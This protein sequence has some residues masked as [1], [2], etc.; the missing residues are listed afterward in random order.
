MLFVGR[1]GRFSE[2]RA[3]ASH[4]LISPCEQPKCPS[5]KRA[6]PGVALL[7]ISTNCAISPPDKP[8]ISD[9]ASRSLVVETGLLLLRQITSRLPLVGLLR[10]APSNLTGSNPVGD[11]LW[12]GHKKTT[13]E[14]S[15]SKSGGRNR[16]RTCVGFPQQIYSLPSL[17]A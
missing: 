14:Q 8:R 1:T 7:P 13:S 5:E 2:Y 11:F 9:S 3:F 4:F 10:C 12:L 15:L 16:I 17:A 6:C